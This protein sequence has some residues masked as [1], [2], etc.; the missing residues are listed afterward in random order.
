[1]T[2]PHITTIEMLLLDGQQLYS[3]TVVQMSLE[4]TGLS[5]LIGCK[6]WMDLHQSHDSRQVQC[7]GAENAQRN[8]SSFLVKK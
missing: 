8:V 6:I 3:N 5:P 7:A 4:L 1:M 2:P